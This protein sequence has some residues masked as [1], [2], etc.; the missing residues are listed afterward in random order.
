ME[1]SPKDKYLCFYNYV[2][3]WPDLA[4]GLYLPSWLQIS[5]DKETC[6][7]ILPYFPVSTSREPIS[8]RMLVATSGHIL[9]NMEFIPDIKGN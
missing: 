4:N 9:M 3:S 2:G 8:K 6:L 7:A 5:V 1:I